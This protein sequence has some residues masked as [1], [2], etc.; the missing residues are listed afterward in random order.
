VASCPITDAAAT[1]MIAIAPNPRS[2]LDVEL[3]D[4]CIMICIR[5][6]ETPLLIAGLLRDQEEARAQRQRNEDRKAWIGLLA[7]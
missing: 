2:C 3:V 7:T 4:P 5:A 6:T 1:A